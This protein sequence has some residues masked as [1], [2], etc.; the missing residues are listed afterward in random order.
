[1]I[2]Y[3][4][5]FLRGSPRDPLSNCLGQCHH[6]QNGRITQGART[7]PIVLER[8]KFFEEKYMIVAN[9]RGKGAL[10]GIELVK[11]RRTKAPNAEACR[12]I[13]RAFD[14]ITPVGVAAKALD[15]VEEAIEETDKQ[16]GS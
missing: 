12:M 2:S 1:M 16:L 6:R 9:T 4:P 14:L 7:G 5:T 11:D 3:V 8:L 10:L 15:I 13:Y